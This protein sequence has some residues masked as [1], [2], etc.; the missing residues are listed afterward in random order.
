MLSE[1]DFIDKIKFEHRLNYVG[2]DCAVF[3]KDDKTD[4]VITSD[5]LVEDVDFRIDWTTPEFLGHKALAVSL[6][7]IAAMGAS[8]QFAML[9]IGIPQG[10]W[11]TDLI[12]RFYAGWH[13]LAR[14]FGVELIGGDTS[15]TPDTFVIDSTVL[16]EVPRGKATL[17]SGAKPGD[18][19]FVSGFL[20]G[21]A[22]GLQLL[23]TGVRFDG[24]LPAP[25][26]HLLFRQL[27]PLAQVRTAI[28]LQSHALSTSMI[29]ISDG[30][31]SELGHLAKA[32]GVGCR[33]DLGAI[34]VDPAI[35]AVSQ[36]FELDPTELALHGGEDFELLLAVDEKNFS[37]VSDLGFHHIGKVTES[38]GEL[39]LIDGSTV[40]RLAPKGYTHF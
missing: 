39:E 27:Q 3:P 28:H 20:G 4:L 7:D 17:R 22:A 12:D 14:Q 8:P 29:D 2:D 15:R 33:I 23:E 26:K 37:A 18:L 38:V 19:L 6:S 21:A 25:I 10:L 16:G 30:L 1:F 9:S 5:L 24:S 11:K 36:E 35:A 31:S 40:T 34:P 13:E 32:S